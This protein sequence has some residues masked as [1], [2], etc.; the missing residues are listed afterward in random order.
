MSWGTAAPGKEECGTR[1]S[2]ATL[3]RMRDYT[4]RGLYQQPLGPRPMAVKIPVTGHIVCED[5]G[6]GCLPSA[7]L[8]QFMAN[9]NT[10]YQGTGIQ[11]YQ[12]GPTD[13]IF[14]SQY[15]SC[16]SRDELDELKG[17]NSTPDAI[18]LYFVDNADGHCGVSAF[19]DQ[20]PRAS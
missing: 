12:R 5:D 13:Y 3:E 11:F 16:D 19:P 9:L 18:D 14:S 1:P 7:D 17:M 8:D 6:S 20:G 15:Y 10:G 2:P 4:Q